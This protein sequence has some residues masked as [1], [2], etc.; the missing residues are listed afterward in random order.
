[1]IIR[2]AVSLP[3]CFEVHIRSFYVT[4]V[5]WIT[6]THIANKVKLDCIDEIQVSLAKMKEDFDQ[7]QGAMSYTVYGTKLS[8]YK[9]ALSKFVAEYAQLKA[10]FEIMIKKSNCSMLCDL[11]PKV[12]N[13]TK[14]VREHPMQIMLKDLVYDLYRK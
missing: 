12:R 2:I 9:G 7:I 3:V 4:I 10:D 6:F 14:M 13:L 1:M 8:E 5:I 11:E